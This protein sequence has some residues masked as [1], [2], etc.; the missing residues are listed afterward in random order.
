[1]TAFG[2]MPAPPDAS[3][4]T[5]LTPAMP[6]SGK[7]LPQLTATTPPTQPPTPAVPTPGFAIPATKP[8]AIVA[9]P[10]PLMDSAAKPV[11]PAP[12]DRFPAAPIITCMVLIV[13]ASTAELMIA[14]AAIVITVTHT[15]ATA[16]GN[17]FNLC[18]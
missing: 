14:S 6:T 8:V 4:L 18:S 15:V 7:V 12:P 13:T 3:A 10:V 2:Q 16:V 5:A 1:M 17:V 11:P 9:V